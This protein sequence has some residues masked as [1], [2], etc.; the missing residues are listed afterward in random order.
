[1]K[2]ANIFA[3]PKAIHNGNGKAVFVVEPSTTEK[4]V[5]A[6]AKIFTGKLGGMP[7]EIAPGCLGTQRAPA[8]S[9]MP[10]ENATWSFAPKSI[11]RRRSGWWR[12]TLVQPAKMATS[13]RLAGQA[14]RAMTSSR[15]PFP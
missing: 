11:W 6:L 13:S 12:P 8:S 14:R 10:R 2:C 5:D 7:W 15:T 9:L 4:Q 1:V 3:W